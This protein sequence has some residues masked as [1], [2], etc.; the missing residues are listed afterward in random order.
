MPLSRS[1]LAYVPIKAKMWA[2]GK[3][4]S[5]PGR[6]FVSYFVHN[7]KSFIHVLICFDNMK[8]RPALALMGETRNQI[9]VIWA[10]R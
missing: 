6:L 7:G 4:W 2:G 1:A 5:D 8:L 10:S 9:C 3:T